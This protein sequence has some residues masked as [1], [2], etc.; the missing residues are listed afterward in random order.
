M[1]CAEAQDYVT[2]AKFYQNAAVRVRA[3]KIPRR[4][5]IMPSIA[6]PSVPLAA[7]ASLLIALCAPG[8]VPAAECTAVSGPQRTALLE[9]YTSEGCDSCPPADKWLS[10]L[11]ARNL[12]S[13]RLLALA[14][15]VDYWNYIGWVDPYAQ[16]RFSDRQRQH[17]VRR[18]ASFVY[19]PQFLLNGAD[20]RRGVVFDDIDAKVKAIN[21][22]QPLADI[23]LALSNRGGALD[24]VADAA[25]APS[26]PRG[27][28]LFLALYESNLLT[29]VKAG[30]NKGRTLRHDFVVREL[31]GPL[32]FD[33]NGKAHHERSFQLDPRWKTRDLRLGAFVQH[34]RTGDVWQALVAAC[35]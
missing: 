33:D 8:G 3:A 4:I 23:R 21:Q 10:E 28:Q 27:A 19:T 12:K 11:A 14:F 1:G 31:A 25:T 5:S 32:A 22:T 35:H 13:D 9:L 30:E 24:A 2:K 7:R 16:A 26:Q 18:R 20:Y 17:S 6:H 15:H 29:A 34:P